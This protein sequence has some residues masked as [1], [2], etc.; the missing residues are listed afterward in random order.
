MKYIL[1]FVVS[2]INLHFSDHR[3]SQKFNYITRFANF[4]H[5]LE[6]PKIKYIRESSAKA[7]SCRKS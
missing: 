3:L 4:E 1:T 5:N 6:S 7:K 2:K